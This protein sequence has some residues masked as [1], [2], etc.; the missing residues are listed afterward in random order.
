LRGIHAFSIRIPFASQASQGQFNHK[1]LKN[2][3]R[4]SLGGQAWSRLVRLG[5][6]FKN[7][8]LRCAARRALILSKRPPFLSK[9][10]DSQKPVSCRMRVVPQCQLALALLAAQISQLAADILPPLPAC[11]PAPGYG[12]RWPA[13][14]R[15]DG[16]PRVHPLGYLIR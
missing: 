16:I 1:K 15:K 4:V 2:I 12:S 8:K 5:G 14:K 10:L 11:A 7:L 13:V 3:P 9:C 6:I